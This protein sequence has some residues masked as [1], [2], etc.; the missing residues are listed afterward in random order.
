MLAELAG[1]GG[2]PEKYCRCPG[3]QNSRPPQEG[4]EGHGGVVLGGDTRM[5]KVLLKKD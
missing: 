2:S 5:R 1:N 3:D 4:Q